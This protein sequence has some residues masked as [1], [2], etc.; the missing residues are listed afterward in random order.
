[1]NGA[2]EPGQAAAGPS[3]TGPTTTGPTTAGTRTSHALRGALI[4][5]VAPIAVYYAARALGAD[6]WVALLAGGAIPAIGV[7]A[8]L[9]RGRR[10][11]TMGILILAALALSA[12]VSLVNGSPR[13]LLARDGLTTGAWACYM[14][15]SLLAARPA[16]FVVSR[17]LLEGRRAFDPATRG[18]VRPAPVSWDELW[19]RVPQWRRIWR[20]CTVIWGSAILADA[21]IRVAMAWTLPIGVVPALS[22][23]LWPVTFVVLQVLTN[24]YFARSGFWRILRDGDEVDTG[25][26]GGLAAVP[27]PPAG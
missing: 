15:L 6:V 12:T 8:G 10:P 5:I 26:S 4:D 11:D 14:Y 24:V 25:P 16:T 21:V 22:G 20:V 18:W 27:V 23:A 19:T 1:V 2:P 13:A 7:L 3:T 17:P 9:S